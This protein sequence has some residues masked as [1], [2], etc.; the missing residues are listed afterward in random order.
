MIAGVLH[1]YVDSRLDMWQHTLDEIG[2]FLDRA[3]AAAIQP[4]S[5]LEPDPLEHPLPENH[6]V[7]GLVQTYAQDVRLL[8][9]RLAEM[10]LALA[11]DASDP[12]FAPE[13]FTSF[14]TRGRH[15][16]LVSMTRAVLDC[17]QASERELPHEARAE[18]AS[19]LALAAEFGEFFGDFPP[20]E[21]SG[22]RIRVHGDLHLGQVLHT[23]DD[24]VFIDFEG[25]NTLPLGE[26]VLKRSPLV[27]LAGILLSLRYAATSVSVL[28]TGGM[29]EWGSRLKELDA[30]LDVWLSTTT[31]ACLQAY[32][33]SLAGSPLVPAKDD[34]F[35]RLLNLHLL[36][37]AVYQVGYDLQNRPERAKV[38]LRT[39]LEVVKATRRVAV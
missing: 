25:D 26:R 1:A 10:H 15:H 32:R 21:A 29:F 38:A 19:A 18:A 5:F 12:D 33:S 17:L 39:L 7:F 4:P 8:G 3:A 23:G 36:A 24:L 22:L 35:R 20:P 11:S 34:D 27:D 13:P 37:K 30:W 14:Y 31:G 9:Y 2:L 6:P 28:K 16:S